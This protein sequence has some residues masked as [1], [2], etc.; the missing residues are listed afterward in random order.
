M[1]SANIGEQQVDVQGSQQNTTSGSSSWQT[2]PDPEPSIDRVAAR[3]EARDP[4]CNPDDEVYSF[5]NRAAT[6]AYIPSYMYDV[7]HI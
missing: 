1:R 4:T 7:P 5:R 3:A 6:Y 2:P